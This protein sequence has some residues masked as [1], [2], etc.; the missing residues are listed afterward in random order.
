MQGLFGLTGGSFICY[1]EEP[2]TVYDSYYLN[3]KTY[4]QGSNW[5]ISYNMLLY[6]VLQNT[7]RVSG[8]KQ[9]KVHGKIQRLHS[10]GG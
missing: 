5:S 1:N 6:Y 4:K 9:D 2:V 10:G 7:A 8:K 3:L